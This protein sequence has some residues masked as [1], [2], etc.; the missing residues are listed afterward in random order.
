M[1]YAIRFSLPDSPGMLGKVATALGVL[2]AGIVSLQVIDRDGAYAV[3]EITVEAEGSSPDG[4]REAIQSVPGVAVEVV[5]RVDRTPDPLAPL[6]LADRL[7]RGLATPLETLVDGLPEALA[8]GWAIAFADGAE[9]EVIAAS[10]GAVVPGN[11]QTPWLPLEGAR[12][13]HYGDWMP[14]R[15]R[16][17]RFELAAVSLSF[18]RAFVIVGRPAG[19][20][21]RP[22]ELRQLEVLAKMAVRMA[23]RVEPARA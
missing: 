10:P 21:Y 6:L 17:S 7:S 15:W 1:L 19:V 5:R 13:L 3:D 14:T 8:S 2:P 20:R 4:L 23:R 12:R 22:A 16:M 18:P 11:L 9:P